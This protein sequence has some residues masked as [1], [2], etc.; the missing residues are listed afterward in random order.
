MSRE[1]YERPI[2]STTERQPADE[3]PRP[4]GWRGA[5]LKPATLALVAGAVV[6]L[7]F[8]VSS[9]RMLVVRAELGQRSAAVTQGIADLKSE[10]ARLADEIEYWRSDAG[11]ERLARE[12]L[13]WAKPGEGAVLVAGSEPAQAREAPP[14]NRPRESVP[15]WR[16]WWLVFFGG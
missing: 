16:R 11:L 5:R 15:N 13:G 12:Q 7:L 1:R 9:V 8:A 10:N 14:A 4:T 2:D 3:S 6:L